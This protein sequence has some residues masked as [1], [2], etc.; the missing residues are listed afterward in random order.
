MSAFSAPAACS[1]KP[2]HVARGL[3]APRLAPVR[4]YAN[5]HPAP[6]RVNAHHLSERHVHGRDEKEPCG[7]LDTVG[8]P[9]PEVGYDPTKHADPPLRAVHA[10]PDCGP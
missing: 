3:S 1:Q 10:E 8:Q 9:V 4:R 2:T 6:E 7:D 5:A